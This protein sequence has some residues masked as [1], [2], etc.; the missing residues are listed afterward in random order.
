VLQPHDEVYPTRPLTNYKLL[1][2]IMMELVG[3]LKIQQLQGMLADKWRPH[4]E[5]LDTVYTDCIVLI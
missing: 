5:N 2:D 3:K 4:M 1:D